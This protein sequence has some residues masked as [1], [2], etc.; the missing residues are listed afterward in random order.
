MAEMRQFDEG[1]REGLF[2]YNAAFLSSRW[3][4]AL[5]GQWND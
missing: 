4:R 3:P 5:V 2:E 1:I